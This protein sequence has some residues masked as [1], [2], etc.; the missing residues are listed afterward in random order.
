[1]QIT[2]PYPLYLILKIV[3][4]VDNLLQSWFPAATKFRRLIA[5]LYY[6]ARSVSVGT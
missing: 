1:M 4:L 2:R 5:A 3:L 6:A